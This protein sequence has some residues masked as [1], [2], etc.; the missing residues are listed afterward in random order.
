MRSLNITRLVTLQRRWTPDTL[1][2]DTWLEEGRSQNELFPWM[3]E[4]FQGI[5]RARAMS[6]AIRGTRKIA[7]RVRIRA[8]E[9]R[10]SSLLM[11]TICFWDLYSVFPR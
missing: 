10:S 3:E 2:S 5:G 7:R 1:I 4:V 6:H 8:C 9:K 11:Q